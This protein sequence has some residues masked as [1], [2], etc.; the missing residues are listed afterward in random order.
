LH[1]TAACK[2]RSVYESEILEAVSD[3]VF[4][5]LLMGGR[6]EAWEAKLREELKA[7]HAD[8][9]NDLARIDT[10]LA[11]LRRKVERGKDNLAELPKDMLAGVVERVRQWEG[12]VAVLESRRVQVERTARMV[13]DVEARVRE[14]AEKICRMGTPAN[15]RW[16]RAWL[17]ENVARVE[18]GFREVERTWKGKPGTRSELSWV[19]V[20]FR[21]E[22][23][24][25]ADM[26]ELCVT[27]TCSS[28]LLTSH[29]RSSAARWCSTVRST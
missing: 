27:E 28:T 10:E 24:L 25:G 5:E 11:G 14:A 15:G 7:R 20:V 12:R 19:R 21:P 26:V 1:G 9:P 6:R 4:H 22:A 13:A 16:D 2:F 29:V 23:S 17:V 8:A 3:G 18:C